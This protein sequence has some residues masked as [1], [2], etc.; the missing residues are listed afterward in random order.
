M[1]TVKV[2]DPHAIQPERLTADGLLDVLNAT[3]SREEF[4]SIQT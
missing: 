4:L 3:M 1:A 2:I